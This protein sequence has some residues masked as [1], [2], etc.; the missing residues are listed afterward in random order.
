MGASPD[1]TTMKHVVA[2]LLIYWCILPQAVWAQVIVFDPNNYVENAITALK[3]TAMLVQEIKQVEQ[4]IMNLEKYLDGSFQD[5]L[6]VLERLHE[7]IGRGNALAY[8][9]ED[10]DGVFREKYPGYEP[11]EDWNEKYNDWTETT[12]DT[13]RGALNAAKIQSE[14]LLDEQAFISELEALSNTA[15]G[16]DQVLQAGNMIASAEVKQ[17]MKLRELVMTQVNSQNVYLANEANKE[18]QRNAKLK[19]WLTT[20]S[21]EIPR[22]D[23]GDS[24]GIGTIG[25]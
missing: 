3:T 1:N 17:L 11:A 24:R 12:L 13:L 18:A 23:P 8:S 6:P 25:R 10:L 15:I 21:T 7:V 4:E 9:M 22:Y 16:R 2:A 5:L 14:D 20:G 19:E